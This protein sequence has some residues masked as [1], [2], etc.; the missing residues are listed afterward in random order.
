[1]RL[2]VISDVHG[3][4]DELRATIA[5][6]EKH[7]VDRLV[8][9]GDLLDRGPKSMECL[10]FAMTATFR[11]RSGR[12]VR[13]ETIRGNH[14]DGYVRHARGL[15]KPGL[16]GRYPV[17]SPQLAAG[18]RDNEI[19]WMAGL[20]AMIHEPRLN[21]TLV[22][23]GI[24][25]AM[26]TLA[27]VD[28]RALRVRFLDATGNSASGLAAPAGGCHWSDVYD[29][30]FGYVV[31]GHQSWSA[32]RHKPWSLG[33]D[34][35]GYGCMRAA[36]LSNERSGLHVSQILS[37]RMESKFD[38]NL[39]A[40]KAGALRNTK[41]RSTKAEQSYYDWLYEYADRRDIGRY[42]W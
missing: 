20:P 24:L 15:S 22:H 8:L 19:E 18:L 32:A 40:F 1:M 34:G 23:G 11:A 30:R 10:D 3:H 36:V 16:T 26:R 2:G 21:V 6:V 17:S 41:S 12:K 29:G 25:P 9:L 28:E 35:E 38:L 7:Q 4:A 33:L 39:G 31:Y 27:D 5:K 14:E 13:V 37:T 42:G